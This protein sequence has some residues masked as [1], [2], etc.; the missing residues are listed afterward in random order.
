MSIY[1]NWKWTEAANC[2]LLV[3]ATGQDQ[4]KSGLLHL[5][6]GGSVS[7]DI[8]GLQ[9][10]LMK[11]TLLAFLESCIPD[12]GVSTVI[13]N[14]IVVFRRW[15]KFNF[16]PK[17]SQVKSCHFSWKD[18]HVEAIFLLFIKISW[19]N[20]LEAIYYYLLNWIGLD[21][22]LNNSCRIRKIPA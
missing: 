16:R 3:S 2:S 20:W 8:T 12:F 7:W 5:L 9:S 11:T 10:W 19:N 15:Y 14:R 1:W 17:R 18:R 13:L 4:L 21:L 6:S 22:V